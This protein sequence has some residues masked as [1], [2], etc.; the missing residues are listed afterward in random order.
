MRLLPRII[1]NF[2]A[3]YSHII[4]PRDA[5]C[6]S[7][8][9]KKLPNWLCV[10]YINTD[11]SLFAL[12]MVYRRSKHVNFISFPSDQIFFVNGASDAG[13]L[14]ADQGSGPSPVAAAVAPLSSLATRAEISYVI[15]WSHIVLYTCYNTYSY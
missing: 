11:I 1:S 14:P 9:Y 15:T 8:K 4:I 7:K 12:Y 5:I 3:I 2:I 13:G 6:F 10:R